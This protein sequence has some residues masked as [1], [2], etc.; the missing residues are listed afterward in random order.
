VHNELTD[1]LAEHTGEKGEFTPI[2]Q[3]LQQKSGYLSKKAISEL[4]KPADMSKSVNFGV[5]SFY[6]QSCSTRNAKV[7][8][9]AKV[10]DKTLL[11]VVFTTPHHSQAAVMFWLTSYWVILPKF[12]NAM[13]VQCG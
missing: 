5:D 7:I 13:A 3:G 11:R 9:K 8:A 1:F 2:P 6:S 10:S 12:Q 4:S